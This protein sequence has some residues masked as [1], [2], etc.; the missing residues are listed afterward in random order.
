[1]ADE[2]EII[3]HN[4]LLYV[5]SLDREIFNDRIK[6]FKKDGYSIVGKGEILSHGLCKATLKKL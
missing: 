6:Q 3:K 4:D 5:K 1:M 2:L